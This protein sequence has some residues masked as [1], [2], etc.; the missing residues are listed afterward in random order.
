[1][2]V[3]CAVRFVSYH[4]LATASSR[5]V[6]SISTKAAPSLV[7]LQRSRLY[8]SSA[9]SSNYRFTKSHEWVSLEGD[10]AT[11]GIS[12]HAQDSLGE[13]VYVDMPDVGTSFNQGDVFGTVESVKAAADLY[14]PVGGEV[15]EINGSL[16]ESPSLVNGSPYNEG[17]IVKL[18][19]PSDG[20]YNKL[21]SPEDYNAFLETEN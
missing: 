21:M 19:V 8:S 15:T 20:E 14:A 7:S 10:V 3:S 2:A 18:K 12:D 13:A 11:V 4:L 9:P 5:L 17:W 16:T 6:P 1:M